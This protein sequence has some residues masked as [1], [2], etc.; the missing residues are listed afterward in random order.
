[1]KEGDLVRT[2]SWAMIRADPPF[3]DINGIVVKLLP[4]T[5]SWQRDQVPKDSQ[6]WVKVLW[7]D[8]I[9]TIEDQEN[10]TRIGYETG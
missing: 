7:E 4:S 2:R 6:Y 5:S 8:G 1:M 3:H 10:M 9:T